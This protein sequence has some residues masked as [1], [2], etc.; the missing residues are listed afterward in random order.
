MSQAALPFAKKKFKRIAGLTFFADR[1]TALEHL[2][3]LPRGLTGKLSKS[4]MGK[5]VL[6]YR[7][8]ETLNLTERRRSETEKRK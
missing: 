6:A 7:L 5:W 8:R 3:S 2:E 1:N 4:E